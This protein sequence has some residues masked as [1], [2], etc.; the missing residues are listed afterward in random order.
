MYGQRDDHKGE[1]LNIGDGTV[2]NL[3]IF[4]EEPYI[5]RRYCPG[6]D[7]HQNTEGNT[8]SG[9]VQNRFFDSLCITFSII[10][11][12]YRLASQGDAAHRHGDEQKIT[13]HNG[14]AGDQRITFT[15]AAV[16]L[17]HGVQDDEQNAVAS[18]NEERRETESDNPFHDMQVKIS[19]SKTHR[20]PFAE[21][22]AK[23]KQTGDNLRDDCCNGCTGNAHM[24]NEDKKRIEKDIQ[25]CSNHHRSHTKTGKSL[26]D[27]KTV[28]AAGD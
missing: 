6:H 13:L 5:D 20:H 16:T 7:S 12:D 15:G 18:E 3:R 27:Q 26:G 28:H 10:E 24:E 21:Q 4:C 9:D 25:D 14:C 11:A 2:Q 17:Q 19:P 1:P 8:Q 23:D 22:T